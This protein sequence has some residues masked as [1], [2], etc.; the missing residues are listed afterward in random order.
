MSNCS[1][2]AI[3][4]RDRREKYVYLVVFMDNF[5]FHARLN[6]WSYVQFINGNGEMAV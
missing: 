4:P 6:P 3:I 5:G 1:F 2:H